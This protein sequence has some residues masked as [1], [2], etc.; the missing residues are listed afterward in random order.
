MDYQQL[1]HH[2]TVHNKI[3][4]SVLKRIARESEVP[5]QLVQKDFTDGLYEVTSFF[6]DCLNEEYPDAYDGVSYCHT[7]RK[8]SLTETTRH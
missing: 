4:R 5:Y 1:H 7:C 2:Q 3:V 6:W 8:F